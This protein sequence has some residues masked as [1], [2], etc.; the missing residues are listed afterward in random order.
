MRVAL[1]AVLVGLLCGA[2]EARKAKRVRRSHRVHHMKVTREQGRTESLAAW[3]GG[4]GSLRFGTPEGT[5]VPEIDRL[6]VDHPSVGVPVADPVADIDLASG[7][8]L[9]SD[10]RPEGAAAGLLRSR[11]D[12]VERLRDAA[13][14][15]LGSPYRTGGSDT[16]G[17]DCSGFVL[18]VLQK[19]GA[20]VSGR[21]S[22]EFWKQGD[23]VDRD[24]LQAGDLLF[25]SDHTRR[26]GHVAIYLADGKFVHASIQK[27]VTVS[28]MDEKYYSRRYK[29][30]RRI[31]EFS[32]NL[33]LVPTEGMGIF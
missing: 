32:R 2:A 5:G 1:A 26:I 3:P 22:N 33:R 12:P 15:L 11:T 25:F 23:P 29:G 6:V 4:E 7:R 19:F 18:T 16:A 10:D 8:R 9:A 20:S 28:E 17:F 31:D 30:A 13:A 21:S 24:S 14:P 27:G